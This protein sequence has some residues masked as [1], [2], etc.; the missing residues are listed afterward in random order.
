MGATMAT[1]LRGRLRRIERERGVVPEGEAAGEPIWALLL[2]A[3]TA[4]R[5][6]ALEWFWKV[7]VWEAFQQGREPDQQ[8]P[9]M[10]MRLL[11]G[12][13]PLKVVQQNL[14]TDRATATAY[15]FRGW[16]RAEIAFFVAATDPLAPQPRLSDEAVVLAVASKIDALMDRAEQTWRLDAEIMRAIVAPE[17]GGPRGR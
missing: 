5:R 13:Y 1:N 12:V 10:A 11:D 9:V 4:T 15:D 2:A 16:T 14:R 3:G 8:R 6:Q 17:V 7:E